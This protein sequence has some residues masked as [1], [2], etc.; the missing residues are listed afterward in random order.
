ML[1]KSFI[2]ASLSSIPIE[3]D[4]ENEAAQALADLAANGADPQANADANNTQEAEPQEPIADQ[5]EED[6]GQVLN[7]LL[8]HPT[9][10]MPSVTV[11]SETPPL[12]LSSL[13]HGISI[14]PAFTSQISLQVL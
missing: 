7:W 10:S 13:L 2:K 1:V 9:N 14:A 6:G 3:A 8:N 12:G 5:I 11:S 4:A